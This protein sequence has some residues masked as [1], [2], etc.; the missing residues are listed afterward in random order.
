MAAPWPGDGSGSTMPSMSTVSSTPTAEARI[1][2][3]ELAA[4]R[5]AAHACGLDAHA[6]YMADLEDE[7]ATVRAAWVGHAV[8]EIATFRARLSGRQEG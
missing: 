7:I 5:R 1:R 3:D 2:L 6:D 8:T 4:E